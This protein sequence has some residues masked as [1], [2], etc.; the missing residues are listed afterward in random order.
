MR[1]MKEM[2]ECFFVFDLCDNNVFF[3]KKKKNYQK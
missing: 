2:R 3:K 1:N